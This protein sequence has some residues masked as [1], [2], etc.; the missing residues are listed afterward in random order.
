MPPQ[1]EQKTID[2]IRVELLLAIQ[3]AIKEHPHD[4]EDSKQ[5]NYD[6]LFGESPSNLN[7]EAQIIPTTGTIDWYVIAPIN[8]R[9]TEVDFSGLVALAANDTNY[10]TFGIVN[11]ER[12]GAGTGNLL[13]TGDENTTKATGGSALAINTLRELVISA[14]YNNIQR[15]DRLRIRA[16][17]TNTLANTVTG[18]VYTLRFE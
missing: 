9:L 18:S 13:S 12:D 16:T 1:P 14:T 17:M 4:G 11:L 7:T 10:I 3:E 5:V 8:G 6:D 15:G 2:G